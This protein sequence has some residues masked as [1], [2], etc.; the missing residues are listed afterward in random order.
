MLKGL[1]RFP[2]YRFPCYV[3]IE[4]TLRVIAFEATR[5]LWL[6]VE[7]FVTGSEQET[8]ARQN[9]SLPLLL[10]WAVWVHHG[11]DFNFT[12]VSLVAASLCILCVLPSFPMPPL[13]YCQMAGLKYVVSQSRSKKSRKQP[14]NLNT[15]TQNHPRTYTNPIS[16]PK[17]G[18][19]RRSRRPPLLRIHIW[20]V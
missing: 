3:A 17:R 20:Y 19:R 14:S 9:S 5:P 4:V 2:C 12:R 7:A 10:F 8:D 11:R 13:T 1:C 6:W 18:G 15:Y 16:I